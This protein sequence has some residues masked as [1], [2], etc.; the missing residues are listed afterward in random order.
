MLIQIDQ[1]A[2]SVPMEGTFQVGLQ[3]Y[4]AI[5]A[6]CFV[7]AT[8]VHMTRSCRCHRPAGVI[9]PDPLRAEPDPERSS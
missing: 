6:T 1:L 4:Q 3:D 9:L 5:G 2:A 7:R 8:C